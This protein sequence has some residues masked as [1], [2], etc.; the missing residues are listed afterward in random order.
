MG[1]RKSELRS[2]KLEIGNWKSKDGSRKS[3]DP[4]RLLYLS[5]AIQSN[6]SVFSAAYL[7]FEVKFEV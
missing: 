6:P 2:R 7:K 4:P 1:N 3:E 5:N